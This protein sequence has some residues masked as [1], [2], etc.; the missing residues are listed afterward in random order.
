MK[1]EKKNI[2]RHVH[3]S[4]Q[5]IMDMVIMIYDITISG[6]ISRGMGI[7]HIKPN[8]LLSTFLIIQYF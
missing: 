8:R 6:H 1:N 3:V 5:F 2:S 7:G 4:L